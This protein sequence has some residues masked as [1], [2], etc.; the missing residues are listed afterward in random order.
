M[1]AESAF[2]AFLRGFPGFLGCFFDFV[3]FNHRV[4]VNRTD[5][6]FAF[7]T[8]VQGGKLNYGESPSS[9]VG[10]EKGPQQE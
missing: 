8:P 4:Q 2:W 10:T 6:F 3:D 9:R 1:A 5:A 7:F